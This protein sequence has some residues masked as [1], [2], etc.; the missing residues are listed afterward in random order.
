MSDTFSLTL[1][2]QQG[3]QFLVSFSP[4][5]P[6]LLVDEPP[7]LGKGEGPTPNQ[8]LAAAAAN[9]LSASLLFALS[10]FKQDAGEVRAEAR[11]EIGRNEQN[12]LRV[13]G[14][15]V[16]LTLGRPAADIQHL[17]RILG[18]FEDFCT[19][20]QSIRHGIPVAVTVSDTT[21]NVLKQS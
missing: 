3:F 10:K 18:Q 8:L 21:G 15:T 16:H 12:R 5:L 20:T 17:D 1:T 19:V 2:R 6:G 11:C 9:C 13:S 14:I 7:P 4:E